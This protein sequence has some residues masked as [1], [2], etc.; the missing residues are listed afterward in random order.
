[1]CRS[2]AGVLRVRRMGRGVIGGRGCLATS[3]GSRYNGRVTASIPSGAMLRLPPIV[4]GAMWRSLPGAEGARARLVHEAI[5]LGLTA[6]DTAPLY[7]F[8]RIEEEL[9][10]ALRGRRDRVML[11][12]KVGLRWDG[13]HGEPL[14][15]AEIEGRRRVVRR[16]SRPVAVRKDVEASLRRLQ[17]DVIDLIQVHHY[18]DRT[19][20][21]DTIGELLRLREEGKVRSLGV[22]NYPA[23]ALREAIVAAQ[24]RGG[25]ATTQEHYSL[26]ERRIES[27]VLGLARAKG[28]GV[29]AFSALEAGVLAGRGLADARAVE[30]RAPMG[31]PKNLRRINEAL[32]G[33]ALPMAAEKGVG[34]PELALAWVLAADGVQAAIAG[35]S[36][37]EQLEAL[38]RVP[39]IRLASEE[40]ARLGDVFARLELDPHPGVPWRMRAEAFFRRRVAGLRRRLAPRRR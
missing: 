32:R 19:P 21:S 2:A 17:T 12:T 9:G 20:V 16:D 27:E 34:L 13:D 22:S 30:D 5:D 18:D 4:L 29:L 31:H 26:L 10:R 6:I 39:E 1:M 24:G 8:G 14:F 15:A 28:V 11:L 36:S 40:R 7:E 38:A 3:D 33:T 23:A 25:L 37:S 35:A